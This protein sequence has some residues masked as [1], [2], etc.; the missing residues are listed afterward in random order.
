MSKSAIAHMKTG[1]L[2]MVAVLAVMFFGAAGFSTVHAKPKKAKYGTIKILSTPGGLPISVDGKAYGVTATDYRS[3]D[4]DPG[5]HTIVVILPDGQRWTREIDLPAGRIKCIAV[6]YRPSPPLPKS[7]CPFPVNVSAPT[8]VNE[9][10]I[11]TYTADVSYS[12][13]A[14]LL[15]TWS[16]N[17]GNAR[18]V[19]GAGT[20]TITVD[21]TGLAGQR[22]TA[23]LVVDDGSGDVSCRQTSQVATNIPLVEKR[24]VIG[25]EFDTCC[26]CSNDD[27][28]ARLDNLAV[29]LQNDPSTTTYIFAY[30]GRTS[31]SGQAGRLLARTR[32]YLINDRG[33]DASRIIQVN[34]GF[35]EE[36]CV[37][38]WIVPR[39]ATAPQPSPKVDPSEV[40]PAPQPA[41]RKRPRG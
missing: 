5:L 18:I 24:V 1:K 11:I 39:G 41:P 37:E 15:Y 26:S 2:F 28:K 9:G 27:L 22:I 12:G 7:P 40:K 33:I 29:E 16:V 8:Q 34:G 23:T 14:P 21:S 30:G 38:V 19:S 3:I 13:T 31:P 36:D 32:D 20:S 6:N 17:P 25:R 35:R 10:E 4:L